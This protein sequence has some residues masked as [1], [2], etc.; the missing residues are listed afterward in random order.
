MEMSVTNGW[1]LLAW[2]FRVVV[3]LGPQHALNCNRVP[4]LPPALVISEVNVPVPPVS[5]TTSTPEVAVPPTS[6]KVTWL[7][8]VAPISV[9]KWAPPGKLL[10]VILSAVQVPVNVTR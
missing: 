7:L 10:C 8:C 4:T 9:V 1:D 5:A 3:G 6:Q 2:K